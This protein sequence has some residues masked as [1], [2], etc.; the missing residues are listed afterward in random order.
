[1][2]SSAASH[3]CRSPKIHQVGA[4]GVARVERRVASDQ[5]RRHERADEMNALGG[6]VAAGIVRREL[7]DL[8]SGEALERARAGA[9]G[10]RRGAADS[11]RQSPRTGRWCSSPSRSARR[12]ATGAA[13]PA[14]R[15]AVPDRVA[16]ARWRRRRSDR[17]CRAAARTRK[18]RRDGRG[19]TPAPARPRSSIERLGPHDR[20]GGRGCRIGPRQHAVPR[21]VVRERLVESQRRLEGRRSPGRRRPPR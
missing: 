11:A 1:M 9:R 12:D 3:H 14:A 6:G 2:A 16:P 19:P 8:R 15:A 10:Q 7:A 18:S 4:R 21:A 17:R 13:R 5:Q 20:R